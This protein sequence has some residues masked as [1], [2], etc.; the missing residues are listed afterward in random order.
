M[1]R[2]RTHK[3]PRSE[4]A[5][6]V[7]GCAD[8]RAEWAIRAVFLALAVALVFVSRLTIV[9]DHD[10]FLHLRTGQW[11]LENRTIPRTDPFSFSAQGRSWD[12]HEWLFQVF[13][14]LASRA[15]GLAAVGIARAAIL[16]LALFLLY[17]LCLLRRAPPLLAAALTLYAAVGIWV[18]NEPRPYIVT[19]LGLALFGLA[20][21]R[22]RSGARRWLWVPPA[23]MLLWVNMHAGFTAGCI[24]LAIAFAGQ[25]ADNLRNRFFPVPSEEND[26]RD[27]SPALVWDCRARDA[28]LCGVLTFAA[29]LCN[30]YGWRI[31]L[32]PFKLVQHDIFMN[33]ILEWN[34]SVLGSDS[35]LFYVLALVL[36]MRAMTIGRRARVADMLSLVVFTLMALSS[37]RHMSLFFFVL[38][39]VAAE[40][41]SA[42]ARLDR[43]LSRGGLV[44]RCVEWAF[45]VG[46]AAWA[47]LPAMFSSSVFRVG[48]GYNT[49]VFPRR[50]ADLV[51]EYGLQPRIFNGYNFG[52]Y[53]IYRLY[54]Q[55]RIFID[56]RADVYG[57]D[58]TRTY[59]DIYRAAPGWQNALDVL[60]INVVLADMPLSEGHCAIDA[61][62]EAPEWVL[63]YWDDKCALFVRDIPAHRKIVAERAFRR[64]HPLKT[65][66]ALANRWSTPQERAEGLRELE[67]R[68]AEPEA[69]LMVETNLSFLYGRRGEPQNAL[70]EV[71]KFLKTVPDSQT[72]IYRRGQLREQTGADA[73][74]RADYLRALRINPN[75][76][77]ALVRLGALAEKRKDWKEAARFYGR[78]YRARPMNPVGA[79]RYANT[80]LRF[81]S[82]MEAAGVLRDYLDLEP[83]DA[84]AWEM[85]AYCYDRTSQPFRASEA[86]TRAHAASAE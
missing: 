46:L 77:A 39:P 78:A 45:L 68:A 79:L 62:V 6:P 24:L 27:G 60:G 75:L 1:T 48:L 15:G 2:R 12:D 42:W 55:Y 21:E 67:R 33:L 86:R 80:L 44:R 50:A 38:T 72:M 9:N 34:P 57:A 51:L 3:P 84:D 61:L 37:R 14:Y 76:S 4:P 74:A 7:A 66:A 28:F 52:G 35:A 83:K 25:I 54:P 16:T 11:I 20:L 81:E 22:L 30:P 18:F 41:F 69:S 43:F 5:P 29:V 53:L 47:V 59:A 49:L 36:G 17:R 8:T 82:W 58:I 71:E 26:R 10:V 85:L 65:D 73:A 56:G 40:W 70:V 23:F 63:V 64:I 19:P 13:T 32:F 31:L